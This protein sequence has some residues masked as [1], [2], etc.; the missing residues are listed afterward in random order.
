[1]GL[2]TL[3]F[4]VGLIAQDSQLFGFSHQLGLINQL[5][6]N[7]QD[8][9]RLRGITFFTSLF[10]H[11]NTTHFTQNLIFFSWFGF[12]TE[13]DLGWKKMLALVFICHVL[14]LLF[15]VFVIHGEHKFLGASLAAI[16][17]FVF[18][19]IHNKKWIILIVALGFFIIY[20]LITGAD[21]YSLYAHTISIALSGLFCFMGEKFS[22]FKQT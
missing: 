2:F 4:I 15:L 18:Y 16:A 10:M 5:S 17:L 14:T 6:F 9:W 12:L 3:L 22:W 11:F 20:P 21:K 19:T 13:K 8:P 1:M 7:M